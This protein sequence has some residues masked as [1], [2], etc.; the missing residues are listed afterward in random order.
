MDLAGTSALVTSF[1]GLQEN[2]GVTPLDAE[3]EVYGQAEDGSVAL[4]RLGDDVDLADARGPAGGA[5]L[6]GAVGRVGRGR[7]VGRRRRTRSPACRAR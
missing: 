1:P 4:L 6:R 5:G 2:F 7:H 3:W